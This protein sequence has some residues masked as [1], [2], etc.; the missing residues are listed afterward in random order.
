ML[1]GLRQAQMITERQLAAPSVS[2]RDGMSWLP[3]AGSNPF[4]SFLSGDRLANTIDR[5]PLS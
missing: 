4:K 2:L 1:E 3:D 5:P